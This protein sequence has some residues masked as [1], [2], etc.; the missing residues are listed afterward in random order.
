MRY[1]SLDGLR[2][3]AS[4]VVVGYHALLIVP[5]VSALYVQHTNPAV[6]SPEWWLYA[7]P[8]RLFFAGHE[9]VLTFFVLSGFV[10]ALP[11]LTAPLTGRSALAYYGRRIIRLYLPVWASLLFAYALALL[12]PRHPGDTWLGSHHPPTP[13]NLWHD[14][15]LLFGTSNLNSPL[16]SLTWEVWFSLLMPLM[17]LAIRVTRAHRWWWA[18]I[19]ILMLMSA[20][21]RFPVIR[22]ALPAAWVTDDLLQYIPIF[23][24]G[25]LVAFNRQRILAAAAHVTVWWPVIVCALLFTVSPSVL[26]PNGWGPAQAGWYLLSLVGVTLLVA[27]AFGSPIAKPLDAR[28]V[29][30]AGKRSFSIYLVHEPILVAAA[31]LAGASGWAW[32]LLVPVVV[33]IV[34][35]V[36]EGFYRAVEHP[37]IGLSRRVGR[38]IAGRRS[39]P[40]AAD[41]PAASVPI[42]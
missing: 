35:V 24:I 15:I 13:A 11:F 42:G 39:L 33:P 26:A 30:W 36:A 10:L 16:W 21:A 9:A 8:L 5:A 2:G 23:A 19:P 18:A 31:L 40:D 41:R 4:L 28:P 34:L 6:L 22:H 3:V 14:G 32:L 25:M 1:T 7:T 12:I 20:A 38:A 27:L 29:Q 17:F 37:T